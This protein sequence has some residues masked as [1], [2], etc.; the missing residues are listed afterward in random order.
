MRARL[1]PIAALAAVALLA[2]ACAEEDGQAGPAPDGN[3][4]ATSTPHE[5]G[6]ADA[7]TD[8]P[9]S[10]APAV[11]D[12][13]PKSVLDG[14]P[15]DALTQEQLDMALGSGT[16]RGSRADLDATGPG[17]DWNS[18]QTDFAAIQI[19][20][21]TETGQGLSATYANTRPQQDVFE[22]TDPVAGYPAVK[23]QRTENN[24]ECSMAVGISDEYSVTVHLASS[25]E[26]RERGTH[27][28]DSTYRVAEMLVNNLKDKA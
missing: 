14:D 11:T 19:G 13:L 4:Q 12:P 3:G 5:D 7:G 15:C 17:C 28:C 16:P 2:T 22:E 6:S 27:P 20:F 23:Y 9:H 1:L 8:L 21:V 24:D 25:V 10:G 18:A 26:A